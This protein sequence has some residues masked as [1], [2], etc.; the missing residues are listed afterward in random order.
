MAQIVRYVRG[1]ARTVSSAASP[2]AG[3]AP[4]AGRDA[5]GTG[6]DARGAG[7]RPERDL[8]VA[9][10]LLLLGR[11]PTHGYCLRRQLLAHGLDPDPAV[12]YRA[13]HRLEADGCA[14]SRWSA[15]AGGPRRRVYRLTPAGRAA[16]GEV[17][18]L[19]AEARELNDAFLRAH[20]TWG[21]D[22]QHDG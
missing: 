16:L 8:L 9:W 6:R 11:R 14:R 20:A 5:R 21:P 13:L 19:I 4:R 15:P 3:H 10:L 12:L 17:V 22:I 18:G 7:R 1:D 2:G